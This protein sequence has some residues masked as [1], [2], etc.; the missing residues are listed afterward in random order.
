M[1]APRVSAGFGQP[2]SR[3]PKP[4]YSGQVEDLPAAI[5]AWREWEN[6]KKDHGGWKLPAVLCV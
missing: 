2:G 3:A 1:A 5:R 4:R 6:G